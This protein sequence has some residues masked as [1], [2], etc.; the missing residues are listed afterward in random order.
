MSGKDFEVE[1]GQEVVGRTIVGGRPAAHRKRKLR[2]PIGIEKVLVRAAADEEFR[3]VLLS[4][5]ERALAELSDVL[6]PTER[7]VLTTI[8][9]GSLQQMVQNIDLKRH[10]KKRFMRGVVNAVLVTSAASAALS[11]SA[12]DTQTKGC[13]NY[14]ILDDIRVEEMSVEE[15]GTRGVRPDDVTDVEDILKPDATDPADVIEFT[16]L[17]APGGIL[18][19]MDEQK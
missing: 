3:R 19:D 7:T 11:C 6:T 12:M 5:R 8:P 1:E 18:P 10:G 4:D 13:T 14:D 16:D 9:R 17:P 15:I 2:V